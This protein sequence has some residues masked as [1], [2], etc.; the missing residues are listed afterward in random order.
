MK[1]SRVMNVTTVSFF[2]F[3]MFWTLNGD[4]GRD[5]NDVVVDYWEAKVS[6]VE[7]GSQSDR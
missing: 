4:S 2:V 6:Q 1:E 5:M 3:W 7:G